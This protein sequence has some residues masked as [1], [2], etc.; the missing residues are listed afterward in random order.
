M[1]ASS[2]V[3]FHIP[4]GPIDLTRESHPI[5]NPLRLA[6][7]YPLIFG[8]EARAYTIMSDLLSAESSR[9]VMTASWAPSPFKSRSLMPWFVLSVN[10]SFLSI[11]Q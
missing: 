7:E 10:P 8:T 3:P 6:N 9:P 5:G 2:A 4:G 11:L 1:R